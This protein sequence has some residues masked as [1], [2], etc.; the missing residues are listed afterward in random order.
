MTVCTVFI[1]S[2]NIILVCCLTCFSKNGGG[3]E[4]KEEGGRKEG[5]NNI[6]RMEGKEEMMQETRHSYS[7]FCY[8]R[9]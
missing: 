4:E 1:Y 2:S 3:G 5:R 7:L 6:E 9:I 8:A